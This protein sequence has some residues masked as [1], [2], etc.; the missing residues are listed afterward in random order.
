M[1][2]LP[3]APV[4]ALVI[5]GGP[6]GLSAALYLAATTARWCCSMPAT[7]ARTGPRS[8]ITTSA[9]PVGSPRALREL[10]RRQLADYP[11]VRIVEEQVTAIASDGA[12][13]TAGA[14]CGSW[15]APAVILCVGVADHFPGFPGWETYVGRSLFWCITCDGYGC[16]G[17]RV[18]VTGESDGAAELA[19]QLQRFTPQITLLTDSPACE[20]TP[21]FRARLRRAEIPL[22][23]DTIAEARGA[24]DQFAAIC[25]G[26]G[27]WLELDQLFSYRPASPKTQLAADLGVALS[28][29]GYIQV[30]TEQKANLPGVF[31]AGDATRLHAHQITTAV[32][33]GGQAASAANYYLYPRELTTEGVPE[34]TEVRA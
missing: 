31:A 23:I 4:E 12:S 16:K 33:E 3:N 9:F 21:T 10:G 14:A 27:Q 32:H 30:D 7:V 24:N 22:I 11:Q 5:G 25:T 6:A 8:T 2:D 18:V 34:A 26:G 20:I 28:S 29:Q 17:A 19:L 1:S 13:F 15:Q